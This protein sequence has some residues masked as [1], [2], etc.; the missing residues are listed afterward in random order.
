M[1]E[2]EVSIVNNIASKLEFILHKNK[3]TVLALSRLL[4]I[5]KQLVYR[6]VKREHIPNMSF[7]ESIADYL[8][9]TILEL[10]DKKYFLNVNVYRDI[11]S[12]LN[13]KCDTYKVYVDDEDFI[14]ISDSEF[15]GIL[16]DKIIKVFYKVDKISNDGCYLIEE[17]DLLKEIDILSA[18]TNLIIAQ[19]NDKEVRL[20]PCDTKVVAKLYK[21]VSIIQEEGYAIKY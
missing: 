21:I 2:Q 9:C 17:N 3:I 20:K 13:Q 11:S 14:N 19:V 7:L 18:G 6:I 10:I 1:T 12:G 4:K 16:D 15:F 8:N 5:D